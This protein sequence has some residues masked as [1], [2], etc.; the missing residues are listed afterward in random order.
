M[1]TL[2][3]RWSILIAMTAA[4]VFAMAQAPAKPA[5]ELTPQSG[6]SGQPG[7]PELAPGSPQLIQPEEL[8][9]AMKTRGPDKP[10][11]LYVGPK[12]FY[13]QAHIPGSDFI[14]P[15]RPESVEKLR[16]RIAPLAKDAPVVI[17]CG[18][19]P[20]DHCPNIRPAFAE[21]RKLGFT[22]VRVLYLANNFGSNWK[23]KGFPVAS[24]E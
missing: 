3:L 2:I 7:G 13:L 6:K 24:G 18:C 1:R 22:R 20:W 15:V 10:V 4:V 23:D 11:V 17:Y 12:S 9:Q 8:V 19:C 21:L 16:A 14:G 5:D